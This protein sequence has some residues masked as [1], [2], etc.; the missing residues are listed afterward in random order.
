MDKNSLGPQ[1]DP[2][3]RPAPQTHA[4]G[5]CV[6]LP[7]LIAV[8]YKHAEELATFRR[9]SHEETPEPYRSLLSHSSHMTVT[10]ERFHAERVE[11]Q[12]LRSHADAKHYYR[13]ILLR[14]HA[15]HHVVQYGMVRLNLE[16]VP[17]LPR[18]EILEEAKPLGRVL[19]EHDVLREIELFDL[20]EVTCGPALAALLEVPLGARTFGRTALLHCNREPAIEL[21][22]IVAPAR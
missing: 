22:E 21:L 13:E 16:N 12:V 11:V 15:T 6:S 20:F 4:S 10:V 17:E 7:S 2:T 19:I 1:P 18:N 3:A 9:V 5:T 8:Y 14:T